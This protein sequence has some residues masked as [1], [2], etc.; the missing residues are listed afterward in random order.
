MMSAEAWVLVALIAFLLVAFGLVVRWAH[1]ACDIAMESLAAQSHLRTA[2]T[3]AIAY[4]DGSHYPDNRD[5]G[6]PPWCAACGAA[7]GSWPC[8]A[9]EVADDLRRA[10]ES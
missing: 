4:L 6:R 2:I 1:E 8:A 5:D 7:D 9:R 10:V 3:Q